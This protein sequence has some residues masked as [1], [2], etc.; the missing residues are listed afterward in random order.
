[1]AGAIYKPGQGYWIRVMT[2]AMIGLITLLAA[3]W[4]WQEA[5][6]LSGFLPSSK[7]SLR[8]EDSAD[9]LAE[10]AAVELAATGLEA[11]ILVGTA[12]VESVDTVNRR[13]VLR[14]VTEVD[15]AVGADDLMQSIGSATMIRPA[16]QESGVTIISSQKI[17][18]VQPI[19]LQGSGIALVL[20]IGGIGAYYFCAVKKG[21]VEFLIATDGEMRKVHWSNRKD[22]TNSTVVVIFATFLLGA[23]IFLIDLVFQQIFTA[24]DVLQT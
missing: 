3:S 20:L 1:M 4:A 14:E 16:A 23:A 19:V 6:V 11:P 9:W 8:F 15:A 5:R 7:I 18:A 12:T 10:G 13:T 17:P 21:S 22:I 24:L 2:A